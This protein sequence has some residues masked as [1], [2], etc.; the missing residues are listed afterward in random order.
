MQV[1]FI[2][3]GK[4]GVGKSLIASLLA[5]H[6]MERGLTPLLAIDTDPVNATFAGYKAIGVEFLSI[7]DGDDINPRAFDQ[8]IV[9]IMEQAEKGGQIAVIDNGASSFVPLSSYILQNGVATLLAEAGHTVRIHTVIAGGPGLQDTMQ[10]FVSLAK[11]IP[12]VPLV[13]WLNQY[14]GPVV[15]QDTGKSFEESKAF[16]DHAGRVQ[17]LVTLPAVKPETF[18]QDMRKLMNQRLTF[19]EAAASADYTIMEKQRLKMMWR[20]L[21]AQMDRARL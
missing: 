13:V 15:H 10:G 21:S 9:R 1:D 8:L 5:Q 12:D 11:N 17:A 7:M 14:F 18:G 4:G 16:K 6:Y 20:N 2:L 19:G 3:Q